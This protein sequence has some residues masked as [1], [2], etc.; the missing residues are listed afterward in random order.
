MGVKIILD[1]TAIKDLQEN[2][3]LSAHEALEQVLTDVK[4]DVPLGQG[5]LQ[6]SMYVEEQKLKNQTHIFIDHNCEYARFLY[7]G[8]VMV[9]PH[10]GLPV[11]EKGMQKV[12]TKRNLKFR[13][14][15]AKWLEPYI[16][17]NKKDFVFEEFAKALKKNAGV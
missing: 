3:I 11:A 12:L 4:D 7:F 6:R 8:K 14:G 9:D 13:H 15:K 16:N 10:T 5:G 1:Y 17:G 2:A